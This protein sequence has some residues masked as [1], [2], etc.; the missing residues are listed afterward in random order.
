[1][2]DIVTSF[3]PLLFGIGDFVKNL[4]VSLYDSALGYG[5]MDRVY[6]MIS[7]SKSSGGSLDYS[8]YW[9]VINALVGIVKPFGYA[10]ITTYFLAAFLDAGAKDNVTMNNIIKIFIQLILVVAI[11]G[12]LE[13]IINAFLTLNES[14]VAKFNKL[15][16]TSQK[17]IMS[18]ADYVDKLIEQNQKGSGMDGLVG[19]MLEGLIIWVIHWISLI[20]VL[21]AAISRALDIGWRSILAP[22]GVANCFEGGISSPGIKYLKAL[23]ASILAGAAIYAVVEIGTALSA[24]AMCGTN[25]AP[26]N[27]RTLIA[28][29]ALLATAGAAIG[30]NNKAKEIVG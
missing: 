19:I 12:N 25:E 27:S 30:T 1:M 23:A 3:L 24:A 8:S 2:L 17:T 29:A 18:G 22:I 7:F 21:F 10:L 28:M 13:V 9:T 20:G 15:D 11:V 16:P 6:N 5:I 26:D 14:I 4:A